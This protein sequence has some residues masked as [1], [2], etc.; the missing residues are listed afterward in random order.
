M[1]NG[2]QI[3][4]NRVAGCRTAPAWSTDTAGLVGE[5]NDAQVA[6]FGA[7]MNGPAGAA[8]IAEAFLVTPFS[9]GERRARRVGL[10]VDF[11]AAGDAS[12]SCVG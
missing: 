11:E 3:Y 8:A 2:E 1:G 7:R 12:L 9:G 10:V 4:A 5:H 6:G